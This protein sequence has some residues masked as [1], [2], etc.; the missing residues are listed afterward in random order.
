MPDPS[1]ARFAYR[2]FISYSHRDKAWAD[3]LHKALETY[4]VP[5]RLVG[6]TTAHGVI[7]RRL[8]PVFRDREELSSSPEL[9]TKINQALAQSENL[10]VLCSPASAASRW[11]NEEVL[12]YKRMGRAGRIFCLIVDGEPNATDLPGRA[13]EECFCP[14]LRFQLDAD[15][16]PTHERTEPIAADARPGKDGKPNAKLK[17]IA[18]MLDVGFDALKQRE[19]Q[20]RVRRMTAI[21][22]L[23]VCVM[24]VTSLLAAY[25]LISRHDAIISQHKESLQREQAEKLIGFM[26]GNLRTKLE[27][28]NRLDILNDVANQAAAYFDA[29]RDVDDADTRAERAKATLLLGRVR[30]DQGRIADAQSAFSESFK[31]SNLLHAQNPRDA[32]IAIALIDAQFWMGLTAWQGGKVNDALAHFQA[33][34]PVLDRLLKTQPG[35][36]DAMKHEAWMHQN[37]GQILQSKGDT[38]AAMREYRAALDVSRKLTSASPANHDYMLVEASSIDDIAALLYEQGSLRSAAAGYLEERDL[39]EKLLAQDPRNNA[40]GSELADA[41]TFLAQ[42]EEAL[43]Q[44]NLARTN[45]QS[46]LQNGEL[47]LAHD[48]DNTE[49][50][51]NVAAYCRRLGHVLQLSGDAANAKPFLDRAEQLYSRLRKADPTSVRARSGLALTNLDQAQLAWRSGDTQA[52]DQLAEGAL[53][54]FKRLLDGQSYQHDAEKGMASALILL[55]KIAASS[56]NLPGA[57]NEWT[58]ALA[59]LGQPDP[60]THD[61]DQISL[62]AELLVLLHRDEDAQPLIRQLDAMH[63]RNPAYVTWHHQGQGADDVANDVGRR[64]KFN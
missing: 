28:V 11:V 56:G 46:A 34:L 55:G 13:S 39:L 40:A 14:A 49:K 18:G 24:A 60:D 45:L 9:G 8:N 4:R 43:G 53:Q 7:P 62:R 20:R 36:Q 42:V 6:T 23:A 50:I 3:W 61:P 59:A 38:Q 44:T 54:R 51:G 16:Q 21:T 27:A 64:S 1:V 37:I 35:N 30:F 10:I 5:S 19:Q 31:T 63:Y 48:S 15:G 22:A 25:A 47:W 29:E 33:A 32:D 41:Q 17:L 58:H 12:A 57:R 52:A 26:L 2:A